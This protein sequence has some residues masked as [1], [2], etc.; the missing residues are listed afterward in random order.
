MHLHRCKLLLMPTLFPAAA[1]PIPRRYEKHIAEEEL[2]KL[3][4][5]QEKAGKKAALQQTVDAAEAAGAPETEAA[6]PMES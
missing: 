3:A 2:D 4:S 1:P 5:E 6:A